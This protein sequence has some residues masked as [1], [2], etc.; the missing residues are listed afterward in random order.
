[1]STKIRGLLHLAVVLTLILTSLLTVA[2]A[3]AKPVARH[4]PDSLLVRFRADTPGAE[5]DQARGQA[6]GEVVEEY[7]LVPGLQ[8]LRVPAGR[9][10]HALQSLSRSPFVEYAEPDYE[11]Y[12]T[13]VPNDPRYAD[14]WGMA[15][16]HAPAAW[17]VF[18]GDPDFVVA[19]IDTGIDYN[20]PD[21]AGNIW[22]NPGEIPGNGI[23]DDGNGYVDDVYGWDWANNDNNP[24]DDNGH[25]SHTSGTVG[26]R[27]NNG[28]GVAGVNWNVM[29]MAL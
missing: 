4:A 22:T 14:L 12:S 13:A 6:E 7:D 17:D 21:L 20:H 9:L 19:D 28:V 25:G 10:E 11:V 8:H 23:D 29:L 18:T 15:N 1:M 5:K 2:P 3:S 24:M 27:G 26:A 16:I